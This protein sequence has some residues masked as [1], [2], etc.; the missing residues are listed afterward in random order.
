MT[1]TPRI[2]YATGE[3]IKPG[4]AVTYCG[5]PGNVEFVADPEHPT[6]ET[7][8]FIEE[9]GGGAMVVDSKIGHVFLSPEADLEILVLVERRP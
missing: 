5:N 3:E 8:W 2:R 4:D 9:F 1:E 6:N 7:S